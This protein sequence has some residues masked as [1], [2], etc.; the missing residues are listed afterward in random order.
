MALATGSILGHYEIVSSLGAGGMG[1]V[2]RAKDTK[3]GREVAIKLLLDEVSSD[4]ERLARFEREAR[5]LASLNHPNIATLHGFETEGDTGFLVMELVDGD[6]LAER[7]KRGPIPIAEAIPLFVQ[8]AEGLAAAHERGVVHRDLKPANVKSSLGGAASTPQVKVLDFGLAKATS[9][10]ANVSSPALTQSPTLTLAATQRG[11]ILGTAAYMSPE[12][13]SGK[14]LDKRTDIWAFGVCLYEALTGARAFQGEDVPNTLAAVLRDEVDLDAL[15]GD[16]PFAVRQLLA[17][18]LVRDRRNRLQ[19]IGDARIE[20]Q[21]LDAL[22]DTDRETGA[23]SEQSGGVRWIWVTAGLLAGVALSV[24]GARLMGPIGSPPADVRRSLPVTRTT[25]SLDGLRPDPEPEEGIVSISPDGSMLTLTA[26]VARSRI[27]LRR[28]DSLE[29]VL[30]GGTEGGWSRTE[31]SPDGKSMVFWTFDGTVKRMPI[32][33]GAPTVLAPAPDYWG[34][35][36]AGEDSFVYAPSSTSGL[37]RIPAA[38]GEPERLTTIDTAAGEISHR[39]PAALPDGRGIIFSVRTGE[40][41]E[42]SRIVALSLETGEITTLVEPG[43]DGRFAASGHLVFGIGDTL[44]AAPTDAERLQT[45]GEALP[46][47]EGVLSSFSGLLAYDL[48]HN[49]TLAYVPTSVMAAYQRPM[50]SVDREGDPQPLMEEAVVYDSPSYSPDG[51]R[52]AFDTMVD[53]DRA[54]WVLDLERGVSSRITATGDNSDPVWTPDGQRIVFQ[55]SR[56][57]TFDMYWKRADGSGVA[58]RLTDTESF[59]APSSFSPNGTLA[60][61]SLDAGFDIWTMKPG[62]DEE[63][64]PF[65]ATQDDHAN[66]QFSPSGEWIAYELTQNGQ[67]EIFAR[68]YPGDGPRTQIS[69]A[70]GVSPAWSRSSPELFYLEGNS[71]MMVVRYETN[72]DELRVEAPR[73]LFDVPVSTNGFPVSLFDVSPDASHFVLPAASDLSKAHVVIVQNWFEELERLVPTN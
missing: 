41:T 5:V 50:L 52:L 43:T 48:S 4:P 72:G 31:F 59:A 40:E 51:S 55:S 27:Y 58:E 71:R 10:E 73:L 2:Y 28:L 21:A 29:P 61:T 20:L 60:F 34:G 45:N 65:L 26:G 11:E 38:G 18:C 66:G 33:G 46:V 64:T 25:I 57:G 35:T 42:D 30:L 6:T 37:F 16:V 49:G 32:T 1:E 23:S 24:V 54:V 62:S 14:A 47:V 15:P 22:A 7:I 8:I 56:D 19:D 67:T 44:Y 69:I 12:Q 36:W 39:F 68:P 3:L 17:R 53:D 13:A 70:G 63:P 9:D